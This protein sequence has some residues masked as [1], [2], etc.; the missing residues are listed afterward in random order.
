MAQSSDINLVKKQQLGSGKRR[1]THESVQA[2]GFTRQNWHA[3]I[4]IPD[5]VDQGQAYRSAL[6]RLTTDE[7]LITA[8]SVI[9]VLIAA[10]NVK[11][12]WVQCFTVEII[13]NLDPA[14]VVFIVLGWREFN[15]V[16]S[17]KSSYDAWVTIYEVSG[18]F[19]TQ[20]ALRLNIRACS[21]FIKA[22]FEVC[23]QINN[24]AS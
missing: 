20:Y 4:I 18:D 3:K 6:T 10:H 16:Y 19:R 14:R 23:Y 21:E 1:S 24:K 13:C 15:T 2:S 11:L 5:S 7:V 12:S 9:K 17:G 22:E 8:K